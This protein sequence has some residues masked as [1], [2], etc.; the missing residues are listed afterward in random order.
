TSYGPC[1][2]WSY[3]YADESI[4]LQKLCACRFPAVNFDATQ[5][6]SKRLA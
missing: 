5:G 6:I 2:E 4:A 3:S 1:S